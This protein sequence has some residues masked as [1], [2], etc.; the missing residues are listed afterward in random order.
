MAT[1]GETQKNIAFFIKNQFPGIYRED[2]PELVQLV[3]DYYKF[4]ET[5]TNQHL[6]N[7]RRYFDIKDIDTTLESM[8]IFFKNKFL[9]DLPLKEDIVK[10]IVKNIL[11]LYRR[12]GTPAGIEMFFAIFFEEFDIDIVYPAKRMLKAS[13]SNWRQGV[14]LQMFSNTGRFLSKTDKEYTYADLISRNITGSVSGAKAAVSKVNSVILNGVETPIIYLDEL[15][16]N[17]QVYDSIITNIAGEVVSFGTVNGSL[18]AV[19]IDDEYAQATSNNKLGSVFNVKSQFGAGGKVVVTEL[20]NEAKAQVDYEV[21]DGGYGYTIENTRLQV[22]NQIILVANNDLLQFEPLETLVDTANNQGIVIGQTVRTIGVKMN[23]GNAFDINRPV[24]TLDRGGNN[25]TLTDIQNITTKNESSPGTLFPDGGD[26]N[27]NVIVTSLDNTSI[28]EV[29]LDP[30]APFVNA[31]N[32]PLNAA[33]YETYAPMSGTASPVT[34]STPLDEAFDI[35]SLTIGTITGFNNLNPGSNYT[36]D[37]FALAEDEIMK[38]FERQNQILRFLEPGIAGNFSVGEII[39][40]ANN[41]SLSGQVVS[42]DT[43]FGSITVIPFDFEGFINTDWIRKPNNDD[44][45]VAGVEIDYNSKIFGDN[46]NIDADTSFAEGKIKAVAVDNSGLGY[47][48]DERVTIVN[49]A[50][51][52]QAQ[53]IA[54]AETQGITSGFWADYSGHINGYQETANGDLVYYESGQKIQDS[55]FYQEYS[56]QIKSKLGKEQYEKLLKENVHLAGTKMFGD[57]I[58]KVSVEGSV[59]PRFIRLFNDTGSGSP[60]DIANVDILDAAITNYTVDSTFVTADHVKGG[61]YSGP[62]TVNLETIDISDTSGNYPSTTT[63][64]VTN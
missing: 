36:N 4:A 19:A 32:V 41:V 64:T 30:I 37:V 63:I 13:N 61:G 55:D 15:Q 49:D 46:A 62:V 28:A 44:F 10:F 24:S 21:L 34:L 12:K 6:Y 40:D 18:S 2:G 58:Y 47:V 7:S 52:P 14:Y 11:D 22:S 59:K 25:F 1:Q 23:P 38:K 31:N 42:T 53:G 57:F 54:A 9:A 27:T 29:I 17:F 50:G 45:Q 60:L 20:A 48:S 39:R 5:Q 26:A 43:T 56:Y 16:G 8:V 33:D 3:E 51:V 35:Q